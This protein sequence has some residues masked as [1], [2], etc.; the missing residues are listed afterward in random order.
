MRLQWGFS[1]FLLLNSW[2]DILYGKNTI[3]AS[4]WVHLGRDTALFS[5][6]NQGTWKKEMISP[7]VHTTEASM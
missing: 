5:N 2:I 1:S 4:M 6:Q 7:N 3:A